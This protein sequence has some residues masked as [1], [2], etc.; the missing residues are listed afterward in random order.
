VVAKRLGLLHELVPK[1]VHVAVLVDPANATSAETTLRV[2]EAARAM[3]L[4]IHILN[5]TTRATGFRRLMVS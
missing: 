2:Q 3:G 4:Q 5:A 1:A